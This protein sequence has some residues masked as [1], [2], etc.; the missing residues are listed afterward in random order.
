M[1]TKE[2]GK[3]KIYQTLISLIMESYLKFD[4]GSI[5]SAEAA[6]VIIDLLLII[7]DNDWSDEPMNCIA[8]AVTKLPQE[9]ERQ[10]F[11]RCIPK[12]WRIPL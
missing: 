9:H 4:D 1:D 10:L 5:N 2:Y 8:E 6:S 12:Q 11:M 7:V 3:D